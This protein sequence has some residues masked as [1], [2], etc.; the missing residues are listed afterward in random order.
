MSHTLSIATAFFATLTLMPIVIR[1]FK[2][3]NL[4]DKPDKR[5]IH[6]VSTP[7]LGGIA[8]FAGIL[9]SFLVT[10]PLAE[11]ASEKYFI[12][13]GVL[14][15]LLGV[16]D[17]L[18]S[19]Q[20]HHKLVVQVFSAILVVHFGDVKVEGLNGLFGIE[21]F[22]W[23]FDEVFSI[24]ILVV[25]TNAY[26]LID[27]I[28]GLAGSIALIISSFFAWVAISA[29]SQVDVSFS[30]AIAGSSLA[31]LIYNWHPSKVFMGDTGSMLFG[32]MLTALMIR[33][34]STPVPSSLIYAPV[35]TSLALFILPIYDTLRVVTIR[36]IA[37]K[38]P[39]S[40]DRNHIHHVLLKM[41]L[42]HSQA[43]LYLIGFNVFAIA[44]AIIFQKIGEL[45]IMLVL[46]SVII[47][48][49][50]LLDR[51]LIRRESAR[52]AKILPPEIKYSKSDTPL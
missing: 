10:V 20:A 21:T 36:L 32:F 37:G 48:I 6:R 12:A 35:A 16:R 33:F 42:S 39:L 44:F 1:I 29:G 2:S 40:P 4:L 15:F 27:G 50:A 41:G 49:G 25:M 5:K 52:L 7:S 3:I 47:T 30:L 18:S 22:G 51:K 43:T 13:A 28:D 17:D 8:I 9:L 38:H 24:F 23:F 19:L 26:N 31:F 46:A 34:L 11:M 14:I 45:W